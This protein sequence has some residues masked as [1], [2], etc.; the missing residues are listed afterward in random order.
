MSKLLGQDERRRR[1]GRGLYLR[2][3]PVTVSKQELMSGRDCD[4]THERVDM[5]LSQSPGGGR[6]PVETVSIDQ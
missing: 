3:R 2:A 6:A 1:T 4:S 5:S